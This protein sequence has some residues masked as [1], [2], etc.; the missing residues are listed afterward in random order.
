MLYLDNAASARPHPTVIARVTEVLQNDFGNASA[1]HGLGHRAKAILEESRVTIAESLHALPEE[2]FF[3][4]GGTEA[5]NLTIRGAF[6]A[7]LPDRD[8]V[9]TT[10]LEHPSVTKT[11]RD[12]RRQGY[13][14]SYAEAPHGELD[15]NA[16]GEALGPD[17]ALVSVMQVQNVFGFRF[18]VDKIARLRDERA[19][20]A[21]LHSDAVQAYGKLDLDP[22]SCGID[23]MTVS[24]H[25]IG[26]PKG[27]GAF[28]I[29][30]GTKV[31]TTSFGG[32]QESGLRSGTEAVPLIA[33]FSEA[34]RVTFAEREKTMQRFVDLRNHLEKSLH[35]TFEDVVINSRPE[36]IPS[37]VHFSL[38][39]VDNEKAVNILSD[40][41][42]YVGISASCD[43]NHF[44][45][46]EPVRKKRPTVARLAGVTA[47]LERNSFR[48]SFSKENRRE[49]IDIL[50]EAFTHLKEVQRS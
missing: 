15:L 30:K 22:G 38:P 8:S 9:V 37:I 44:R 13:P 32:G 34:T 26:G 48:V 28:Y 36:G 4:S 11:I 29:R 50:I 16:L 17:C 3:A 39:G 19:P 18:P 43:T 2:I 6:L 45:P 5:N 49:D 24:A 40:Q 25:K 42:I 7:S 47:K 1:P 27:I 21:L 33:G 46:G 20:K 14:V 10:A 41:G 12:I 31:S 35:G 23:L